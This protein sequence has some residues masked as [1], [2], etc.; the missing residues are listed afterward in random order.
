MRF[1]LLLTLPLFL[2]SC[3]RP[4]GNFYNSYPK[5][6]EVVAE[7]DKR[8]QLPADEKT[9]LEL[10]KKPKGWF[11]VRRTKA[12][13][14]IFAEY[15][16]WNSATKH[17][18]NPTN[19]K[20]PS[21]NT[22]SLANENLS[23]ALRS[24]YQFDH[25]IY[26]G[27]D[28]WADD[29][30][31][32]LEGADLNDT[33][34]ESLARAY[35]NKGMQLVHPL[36]NNKSEGIKSISKAEEFTA[37]CDKEISAYQ[38]IQKLNPEYQTLIGN[39]GLKLA[40]TYMYAWSELN[41]AGHQDLAKTYLH[42]N[43][44]DEITLDFAK[45]FLNSADQNGIIFTGGDNDTYPLWYA[46]EKL[47]IRKDVAVINTSLANL[48]E[49]IAMWNKNYNL[50]LKISSK[51]Y[52]DSLSAAV[53]FM[54][55]STSSPVSFS[56]LISG[57]EN[58]SQ[59]FYTH[60]SAA[61]PMFVCPNKFLMLNQ[62]NDSLSLNANYKSSQYL[63][64]SDLMLLD[65]IYSNYGKRSVYFCNTNANYGTR[66]SLSDNL[67]N[68]GMLDKI[69]A[70]AKYKGTR[71][72]G[73]FFNAEL[74]N[75]NLN[76]NYVYGIKADTKSNNNLIQNYFILFNSLVQIQLENHDS[77][78]AKETLNSMS[79]KLFPESAASENL[80][81]F[82]AERFLELGE[83]AKGESLFRSAIAIMRKN[84][85]AQNEDYD[86]ETYTRWLEYIATFSETYNLPAVREDA[87]KL[88]DEIAKD[89]V[90]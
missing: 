37:W 8:F 32:D 68:E 71:S 39:V 85:Q 15:L 19:I 90:K 11:I 58:K 65:V 52:S 22:V 55:S 43:I 50:G 69:S 26:F 23:G 73:E 27:Y 53:Y 44:Y 62:E 54:E 6:K 80:R 12:D 84:M 45:N 75:K 38:K 88:R 83:K 46:Q 61:V 89:M 82:I 41:L 20:G 9:Y 76:T 49:W 14:K 79:A 66:E 1:I 2:L 34:T 51:T 31:A 63:L 81:I 33:L 87:S 17:Y 5:V 42:D 48:P 7:F 13:Q 64:R 28:A 74:L 35:D 86:A 3:K 21:T 56:D 40:N 72:N 59:A 67:I 10:A 16:F 4:N 30:I 29:I 77:A 24:S 70:D 47:G 18:E 57:M 36:N 25:Q 78:A 60:S